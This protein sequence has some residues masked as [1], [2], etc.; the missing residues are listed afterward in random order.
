MH[1]KNPCGICPVSASQIHHISK[2]HS[3]DLRED[4]QGSG[5]YKN[6]WQVSPGPRAACEDEDEDEDEGEALVLSWQCCCSSGTFL[7]PTLILTEIWCFHQ[8]M[9][10]LLVLFL[11]LVQLGLRGT[12]GRRNEESLKPLIP[13]MRL[14]I[15]PQSIFLCYLIHQLQIFCLLVTSK[16]ALLRC[17]LPKSD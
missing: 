12:P 11:S 10:E 9:F 8:D 7:H 1:P 16:Q 6:T 4:S 5:R 3:W 14:P 17:S 2:E 13:G 15:K